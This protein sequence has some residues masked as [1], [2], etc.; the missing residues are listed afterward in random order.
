LL[1]RLENPADGARN[2]FPLTGFGCELAPAHG[3]EFVEFGASIAFRRALFDRN[4][5]ALDEAMES[6]IERTLFDLQDIF[7][8]EFDGLGNSV[9]VGRAR[10]CGESTGRECPAKVRCVSELLW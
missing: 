6:R 5:T 9:A 4:V 10:V 1:D 2:S 8:A 7:R 3:S